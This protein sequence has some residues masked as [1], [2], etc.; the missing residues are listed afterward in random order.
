MSC[1]LFSCTS[2]SSCGIEEAKSLRATSLKSLDSLA[3]RS[4]H[5]RRCN[6]QSEVVPRNA[7][8]MDRSKENPVWDNNYITNIDVTAT[9]AP[10]ED[11]EWGSDTGFVAF[12]SEHDECFMGYDIYSSRP[13]REQQWGRADD[14]EVVY[15]VV[16]MPNNNVKIVLRKPQAST[17]P[18]AVPPKQQ[19]QKN[20]GTGKQGSIVQIKHSVPYCCSGKEL[21]SNDIRIV[22]NHRWAVHLLGCWDKVF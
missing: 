17:P 13:G 19:Q 6:S 21:R 4:S 12:Y 5:P 2:T 1:L 10:N 18:V 22:V 7:K 9:A 14:N 15:G 8:S 20:I 11:I 3:E 16:P